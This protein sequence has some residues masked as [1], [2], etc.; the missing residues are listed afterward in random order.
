MTA[1]GGIAH[2]EQSPDPHAPMLHGAQ[3]W[4]ALPD[5]ER[6][7]APSFDHDRELPVLREPGATATVL[8]GELAGARSPGQV[9]TALIGVDATLV[10]G[11][12]AVLP[13]E[14]DFEHAVLTV[15]GAPEVDGEELRPGSLCYLGTGRSTLR[16]RAETPSRLLLLGGIPFTEKIVMWWNFI[17]RTGEEIAEARER[18]QAE[19]AG[20]PTPT[21][22]SGTGSFRPGP[23]GAV[24]RTM[25][26]ASAHASPFASPTPR[27]STC[28]G[29]PGYDTPAARAAPTRVGGGR[30][31]QAD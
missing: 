12:D 4:V 2:S 22:A 13:L 28:P 30:E 16:L 25:K 10:S 7:R 1:G 18:W 31:R 27:D 5:A 29:G 19:L 24:P 3:L 26:S 21:A 11:A 20:E 14:G 6:G 15:S 8:P 9:H 17:A 23:V